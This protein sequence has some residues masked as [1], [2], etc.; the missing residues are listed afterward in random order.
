MTGTIKK[1]RK[2]SVVAQE[3]G[4]DWSG[5]GIGFLG[6]QYLSCVKGAASRLFSKHEQHT[7]HRHTIK[8][9]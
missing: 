8:I 5:S 2:N 3:E 4:N 7:L 9:K 6:F 1:N